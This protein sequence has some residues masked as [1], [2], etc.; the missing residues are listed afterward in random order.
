MSKK[1]AKEGVELICFPESTDVVF[2]EDYPKEEERSNYSQSR[3]KK[4]V[5]NM[6]ELAKEVSPDRPLI[7]E[8]ISKVLMLICGS[9]TD[10]IV[11]LFRSACA[12]EKRGG[13]MVHVLFDHVT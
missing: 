11:H 7:D 3:L 2:D 8:A 12:I 5:D 9:V 4:F 13:K 6:S 1:A 10:R